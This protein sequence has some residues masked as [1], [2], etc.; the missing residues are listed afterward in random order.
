M[1][2]SPTRI[3]ERGAVTLL[4]GADQRHAVTRDRLGTLG[5]AGRTGAD[6]VRR[7]GGGRRRTRGWRV[8][9][10]RRRGRRLRWRRA[11]GDRRRRR[12][13]NTRWRGRDIGRGGPGLCLRRGCGRHGRRGLPAVVPK[14]PGGRGAE[15]S[16]DEEEGHGRRYKAC[17]AR[18]ATIFLPQVRPP[19]PVGEVCA[20][21]RC[22]GR[23]LVGRVVMRRWMP[24]TVR[25]LPPSGRRRALVPATAGVHPP[26]GVSTAH[27]RAPQPVP[28]VGAHGG[29]PALNATES[30]G[31]HSSIGPNGRQGAASWAELAI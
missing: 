19:P 2:S 6:V 4:R 7:R 23:Q 9:E 28:R 18:P 16:D 11:L 22:A 31:R 5:G 15:H 24:A 20:T 14:A 17:P 30:G 29:L 27:R 1:R 21:P 10:R 25:G 8:G 3:A 13:L 12:P 26:V